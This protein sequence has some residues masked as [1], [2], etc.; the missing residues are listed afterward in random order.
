MFMATAA[1]SSQHAFS[2]CGTTGSSY[3]VSSSAQLIAA[4]DCANSL[5]PSPTSVATINFKNDIALSRGS[6]AG[7]L[8]LPPVLNSI[9]INGNGHRIDGGGGGTAGTRVFFIGVDNATVNAPPPGAVLP[10]GRTTLPR[11]TV[12][13]SNLSINNG[14]AQGGSGSGG[15]MGAGGALF[16][17][18]NADV[19]LANVRLVGNRAIGGR[20]GDSFG[21]GGLGGSG[22]A[23]GSGGG[24]IGGTSNITGDGYLS[25]GGGLGGDGGYGRCDGQACG[26]GGGGGGYS[27]DGGRSP[28]QPGQGGSVIVWGMTSGGGS[29]LLNS[30]QVGGGGGINGG[31]GGGGAF[32]G[33]SGG[34]G[35]GGGNALPTGSPN[36][37]GVAGA[38][39][40][41]GGGGFGGSGG[42]GGDG[43]FGGGGGG[44]EARGGFGGGGG[45]F[46]GDGGF[47]GGGGVGGTD[48]N[49]GFG[50]GG[51]WLTGV[52]GF[53]AGSGG[54]AGAGFGGAVFVVDG[55]TLSIETGHLVG[56]SAAAGVGGTLYNLPT[57]GYAAGSG[58][59]LQGRGNLVLNPAR[60]E[61]LAIG[62]SIAD[63]VGFVNATGYRPPTSAEN[64]N[65]I[66]NPTYTG[67]ESW[68][69]SLIG[70]GTVL[71]SGNNM[72]SGPTEVQA[73]ALYVDGSI[74]SPTSV[75]LGATLGGTGTIV[76]TVTNRG[77]LAPGKFESVGTLTIRGNLSQRPGATL[78]IRASPGQS[79]RTNISGTATLAG[80]LVV[81]PVPGLYDER[82]SYTIVSADDGVSG[83]FDSITADSPFVQASVRMNARDVALTLATR[84][85]HGAVSANQAAAA[86]ALDNILGGSNLSPDM[87][88]ALA[89]LTELNALEARN[90]LTSIA[91]ASIPYVSRMYLAFADAFAG[92]IMSRLSESTGTAD[93]PI[94]GSSAALSRR[95]AML[96]LMTDASTRYA[97]AGLPD[98][99]AGPL[100]PDRGR[101]AWVRVYG[102]NSDTDGDINAF[103]YRIRSSGIAFGADNAPTPHSRIGVG[104]GYGHQSLQVD[105]SG[106]SGT[107]DALSLAAYGQYSGDRWTLRWSGALTWND[108]NST[109]N[110]LGTISTA[111]FVG[112]SQAVYAEAG[113]ALDIWSVRVQPLA[114]L[115]YVRI[116]NR[117][118]RETGAGAFDLTV[119]R[120][121][122]YSFRS[123]VGASAHREIR[124]GDV[125]VTFE[126]RL[127]WTREHGD[128]ESAPLSVQFAG[129]GSAGVFRVQ[130]SSIG[131]NGA[132]FGLGV[133]GKVRKALTVRVDA[134]VELRDRQESAA[135]FAALRHLW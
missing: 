60:G 101:R 48:G 88:A 40:F 113:Y 64:S 65:V 6:W 13:I 71:L 16:I 103:G 133:V 129:G 107:V 118:Y 53:G 9:T 105:T 23:Q 58:L 10:A 127:L 7:A 94:I 117:G 109:R 5:T 76:G 38:G 102:G 2:A 87:Q 80:A 91:G 85:A 18:Q 25:G 134:T 37:G 130:G 59:F 8:G 66:G 100:P 15:G 47:G 119:S 34:G 31:G 96:D 82:T 20:G 35:F 21:G 69:V 55:G 28:G 108:S 74:T 132:L 70:P 81:A 42:L 115:S 29:G 111:N 11:L 68:A 114:A 110:V 22:G 126:P 54:G 50:G 33:S 52:G 4:I 26:L 98:S 14:L 77:V 45:W 75:A 112:T 95:Y 124:I 86:R 24:G 104:V 30:G 32:V 61:T 3:D 1:A 99:S 67:T 125:G 27:G 44:Y 57:Q 36:G 49:G 19:R 131:R 90:A 73:G 128:A 39:G 123:Y 97:H 43:G 121:T 62:D 12:T 79:S 51:G 56:G 84:F 93:I 83:G 106:D 135:L 78:L 122:R 46:G 63:Q 89:R 116:A 41:G 120:D 92:T 17:N 72:Y